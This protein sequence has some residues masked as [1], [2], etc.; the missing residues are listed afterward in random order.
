MKHPTAA[1]KYEEVKASRHEIMVNNF[2]GG[3]A[4]ALGTTV[5]LSV[6]VALAGLALRQISVV[7]FLGN[8]VLQVENFV[9]QKEQANN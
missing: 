2:L 5:G 9:A 3:L 4:W 1:Q 6:V 7:P 8:M